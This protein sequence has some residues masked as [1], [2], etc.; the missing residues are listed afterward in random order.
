MN[1]CPSHDWDRYSDEQDRAAA[2]EVE[3]Y[4]ANRN[5]IIDVASRLM[6]SSLWTSLPKEKMQSTVDTVVSMAANIIAAVH[7]RGQECE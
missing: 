7:S 5:Q 1:R 2:A 4:R 3:F 6:A